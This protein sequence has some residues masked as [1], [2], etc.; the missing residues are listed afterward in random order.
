MLA[1]L[2]TFVARHPR[3]VAITGAGCSVASG[4]PTY[5]D[6]EARWQRSEP[7][8]HQDFD[9]RATSRQR[10]WSRSFAG[11]PAV[12]DARPNP[13][14]HTLAALE[15]AGHVSQLITQN[16]DRLH[17]R[18]GHQKVIDLHGRLDQVVCLSCG[19]KTPRQ[20]MQE[21]LARCNPALKPEALALTPDG[22][23]D[24]DESTIEHFVVP[25]CTRCGGILKPD[26]VFFGGSVPR[27]VVRTGIGAIEAADALV[28]FGSSLMVFS[29]FRFCR[30]AAAIGKPIAIVNQGR[31][32][33]DELATL[34]LDEDCS[35]ALTTLARAFPLPD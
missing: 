18:A 9:N 22:D 13:V 11:W 17:Q 35:T 20:A 27:E 25:D 1:D 10:Y 3:F 29:A 4:I 19:D 30:H 23:A 33:A 8:Q 2:T 14:H 16:V 6:R 21:Q 34:K 15:A 26:V 32:R 5:R 31:T 12:R 28:V 7:I 24:V